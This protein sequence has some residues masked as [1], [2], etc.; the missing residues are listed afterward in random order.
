MPPE[1]TEY[2]YLKTLDA[3]MKTQIAD[4]AYKAGFTDGATWEIRHVGR[5]CWQV[6]CAEYGLMPMSLGE[7]YYDSGVVMFLPDVLIVDDVTPQFSTDVFKL[8]QL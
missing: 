7:L 5:G 4:T 8:L 2:I 6:L 1:S 3:E